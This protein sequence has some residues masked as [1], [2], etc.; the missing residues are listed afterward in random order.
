[1]CQAQPGCKGCRSA[2]FSHQLSAVIHLVLQA[3][4]EAREVPIRYRL[5]RS[6]RMPLSP[7]K[8]KKLLLTSLLNLG[9]PDTLLPVR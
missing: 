5:G 6:G 3:V 4:S 1:M 9:S 7:A 8:S 2:P